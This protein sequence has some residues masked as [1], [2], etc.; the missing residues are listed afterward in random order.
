MEYFF[1]FGYF[2]I[3]K[4]VIII[5]PQRYWPIMSGIHWSFMNNGW[6]KSIILPSESLNLSVLYWI[7]ILYLFIINCFK[8]IKMK[9]QYG[10]EFFNLQFFQ[11]KCHWITIR[12]IISIFFIE[13]LRLS[14]ELKAVLD[15]R[16]RAY[17]HVL[18][19]IIDV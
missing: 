16:I 15:I 1:Y 4:N 7:I 12:T 13:L 19:N 2:C 14:K 10:W 18:I 3:I 5:S 6:E 11:S 9:N 17:S 8:P